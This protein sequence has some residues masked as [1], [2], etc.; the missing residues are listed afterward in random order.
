MGLETGAKGKIE[1]NIGAS[2]M[3]TRRRGFFFVCGTIKI[4]QF[5]VDRVAAIVLLTHKQHKLTFFRKN[6]K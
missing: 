3:E 5:Y 2:I 4:V 6:D 1:I